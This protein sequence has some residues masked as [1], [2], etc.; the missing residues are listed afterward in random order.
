MFDVTPPGQK[1]RIISPTAS[2]AGSRK[3]ITTAYATMGRITICESAPM[4]NAFGD[5]KTRRKSS[6]V[7]PR[8]SENMMIASA[9]G[10]K[11]V[12]RR[13]MCNSSSPK[14]NLG[15]RG[16]IRPAPTNAISGQP[17]PQNKKRATRA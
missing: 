1:E 13:S 11:T 8:P 2:S 7:S 5:R 17:G 12:I 15:Y 9:S 14:M 4:P 10:R 16:T 6:N 3:R